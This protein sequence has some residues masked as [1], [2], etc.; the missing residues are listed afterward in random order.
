MVTHPLLL[1]LRRIVEVVQRR[2]VEVV[3]L[4][5][6]EAEAAS[7]EAGEALETKVVAEARERNVPVEVAAKAAA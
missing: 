5:K 1:V 6:A 2:P 7:R 3:P 4:Q